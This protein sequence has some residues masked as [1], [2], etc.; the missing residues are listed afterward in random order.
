MKGSGS[1]GSVLATARRRGEP[2]GTPEDTQD[3]KGMTCMRKKC[4]FPIFVSFFFMLLTA[5]SAGAGVEEGHTRRVQAEQG[6]F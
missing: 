2:R 6:V 3:E 4:V 1:A 5:D